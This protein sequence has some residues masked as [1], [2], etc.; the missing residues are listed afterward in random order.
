MI[1]RKQLERD[2]TLV[3]EQVKR[4]DGTS[5]RDE[6]E[7]EPGAAVFDEVDMVQVDQRRQIGRLTRERLVERAQRLTA[8]LAR[9]D[10]G[11]YG[12]CSDCG[13]AIHPGRLRAL[14]EADACVPCQERRE[15][16]LGIRRARAA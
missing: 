11:S 15:A 6:H 4:L 8:A 2:L 13:D 5:G 3:V 7:V 9:I 14:P 12:V 10:A 16:P 1:V